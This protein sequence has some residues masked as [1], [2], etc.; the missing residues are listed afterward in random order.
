MKRRKIF[1][2]PVN[3]LHQNNHRMKTQS[4]KLVTLSTSLMPSM[5]MN[6]ELTS[7]VKNKAKMT[8][9]QV[10]TESSCQME[11]HKS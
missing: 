1:L 3:D 10:N 4:I 5:M 2:Q 6:V 9:S 11:E 8:S 7:L